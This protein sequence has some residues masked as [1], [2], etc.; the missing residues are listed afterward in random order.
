MTPT[1]ERLRESRRRRNPRV[2]G[3]VVVDRGENRLQRGEFRL[4]PQAASRCRMAGKGSFESTLLKTVQRYHHTTLNTFGDGETLVEAIH[5]RP[6][7]YGPNPIAFLSLLARRPGL[8]LGD[9]DEALINDRS[10]VRAT[11]FRGSMFLMPT[12]DYPVYFRAL[13]DTLSMTGMSRL[14]SEGID[15]T[16]IARL[17]DR[18]LTADFSIQKTEKQLLLILYPGRE[19][20]PSDD[21]LRT[22]LRKLC[23]IGVLVRTTSKGWKGN[24]FQYALAKHW[25]DGIELVVDGVEAARLELVR[26]YLRAYGPARFED[27][28]WWTGLPPADVRASLEQ[29][30]REVVRFFVD[31]LGEGLLTLREVADNTRKGGV[32]VPERILFLPLWDAYAL[33]WRDRTRVVDPRFAPW[34]YD[35]HGNTTSLIVEEGRAIG[36]WQFRDGDTLT[37]EFHLFEPYNNRLNAV[38]IAAEAHAGELLRVSGARELRV[39]ERALPAPLAERPAQ[40]FMW[41][42]GKEPIFRHSDSDYENPMDRRERTSGVLRSKFLDDERLVRPMLEEEMRRAQRAAAREKASTLDTFSDKRDA[43]K[44]LAADAKPAPAPTT[45][46]SA[47]KPPQPAKPAAAHSASKPPQPAK[48]AAAHSASKPPQPAKPA[49]APAKKPAPAPAKKPAPA[50][51]KKPAPAPAKKPA[52]AP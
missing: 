10:L 28:V 39:V 7:C 15:E 12:E 35:P 38:R 45:K 40:S 6:G 52:P 46:K 31:G 5:R 13:H 9:L 3:D 42:L 11:A 25:L 37:L 22:L 51:A 41:P 1:P 20:A 43:K 29:L 32:A 16:E 2:V 33:G 21:V 44:E 19:R 49:P 47:S 23:D 50:P 18:L 34:V 17:V 30:G 24:Q 36:L 14:R 27:V 48:P 26:R 4:W 8:T